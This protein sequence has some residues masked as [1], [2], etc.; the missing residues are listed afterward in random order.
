LRLAVENFSCPTTLPLS[1]SMTHIS[2]E[3]SKR[4]EI[5]FSKMGIAIFISMGF[6]E[7]K[8]CQEGKDGKMALMI[9]D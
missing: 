8:E 9:R 7:Q 5:R 3:K 1:T 2:G 4:G 6:E